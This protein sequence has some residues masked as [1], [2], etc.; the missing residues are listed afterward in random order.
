MQRGYF[1]L[2]LCAHALVLDPGGAL[3]PVLTVKCASDCGEQRL[4][5]EEPLLSSGGGDALLPAPR[6]PGAGQPAGFLL[7]RQGAGLP[8]LGQNEAGPQE[9]W[10]A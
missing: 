9:D 2:V 7:P 6:K 5:P 10:L 4:H 8:V 1:L 3:V